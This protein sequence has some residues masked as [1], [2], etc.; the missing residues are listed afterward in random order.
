[1]AVVDEVAVVI[2][3]DEAGGTVLDHGVCH[4]VPSTFLL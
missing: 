3:A 1:M 4:E 2:V